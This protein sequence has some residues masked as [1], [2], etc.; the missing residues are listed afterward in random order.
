VN[1]SLADLAR[2]PYSFETLP[3]HPQ[4]EHFESFTSY[5]M[6]LADANGIKSVDNLSAL[7]FPNRDRRVVRKVTDYPPVS[8]D[9]LTIVGNCTGETL[10]ATTFFHVAAKFGRSGLPQPT[11]RF[12]SGCLCQHLRY[13][14]V[15]ITLQRRTCYLLSWRFRLLTCCYKHKCQLLETCGHC[16]EVIPLFI[17]PFKPGSC[18]KCQQSLTR[19]AAVSVPDEAEL[20][21]AR[22]LHD[23]IT[24]LLTPQ[25]W[26]ENS[27]S[28]IRRVGRHFSNMR[29]TKRLAA[30]E[31]ANQI[32]VPLTILQGMERGDFQKKGAT[33]QSYIKYARLFSLSL[34]E[35]F[36][37]VVDAPDPVCPTCQQS[38]SIPRSGTP[39]EYCQHCHR[40]FA[41]LPKG[42]SVQRFLS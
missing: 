29:R 42:R 21:G 23:E 14:P 26:E 22:H 7:C 27:K 16:G 41:A 32:G 9:R 28:I 5:L 18:P 19:C 2:G 35:V 37:A 31:V 24:F 36:S 33:L 39:R 40:G 34:K 11:S 30:G 1:G 13:C 12:L 10:L 15:C 6:R 8:F 17:S 25:L 20:E 38:A 4:P 3:L